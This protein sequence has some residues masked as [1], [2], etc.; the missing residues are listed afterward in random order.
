MRR[1]TIIL[2]SALGVFSLAPQPFPRMI[3]TVTLEV[4]LAVA[5]GAVLKITDRAGNLL[6]TAATIV[7]GPAACVLTW[8]SASPGD[9]FAV[10]A[11]FARPLFGPVDFASVGIPADLILAPTDILSVEIEAAPGD[12]VGNVALVTDD[13]WEWFPVDQW[14]VAE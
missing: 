3:C 13:H 11:G 12:T 10:I 2:P 14:N 5:G 6:F 7:S 9:N 1:T 4:T 8:S